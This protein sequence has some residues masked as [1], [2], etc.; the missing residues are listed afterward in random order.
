MQNQNQQPEQIPREPPE[1]GNEAI[2]QK[3][4]NSLAEAWGVTQEAFQDSTIGKIADF[5]LEDQALQNFWRTGVEE[6]GTFLGPDDGMVNDSYGQIWKGATPGEVARGREGSENYRDLEQEGTVHGP[7]REST[8]EP[9][10]EIPQQE[11]SQ[12]QE[13]GY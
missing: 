8:M 5:V 6:L 1:K 7:N 2:P 12:N 10:N 4:I 11:Q 3:M 9:S 13:L